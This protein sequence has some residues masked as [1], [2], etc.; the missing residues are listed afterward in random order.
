MKQ[1]KALAYNLDLALSNKYLKVIIESLEPKIFNE[2]VEVLFFKIKNVEQNLNF[3]I[4]MMIFKCLFDRTIS[5][6]YVS[7]F[8]CLI[9]N[10][11]PI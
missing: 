4:C 1:K 3:H 11:I 10:L 5:R 9:S 7:T 6:L 8:I 2:R